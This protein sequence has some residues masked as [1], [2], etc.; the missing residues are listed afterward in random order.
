MTEAAMTVLPAPGAVTLTEVR[1]LVLPSAE[2]MRQQIEV[3][4]DIVAAQE[5]RRQLEA[6]RKYFQDRE[7]RDLLAA[8]SRRTEILIGKL[9]GPAEQ[10]YPGKNGSPTGEPFEVS[11]NDRHKFRLLAAHAEEVEKL[12]TEGTVSRNAILERIQRRETAREPGCTADLQRLVGTGKTFGAIY[13]DPPWQYGN[14]ATRASTDNHYVTM[15]VDS[16]AELPVGKL[17][18]PQS[19]LWLW[20]TNGFLFECPRLFAAWGFEFKSSYVWVK[21]Q[22]GIG[23]Y[24]RNAHEFLLLAVR[25]GL[26]ADARDVRS[27]GQFDRGEH[28][29]KPEAIR[30][31]VV[32]RISPG[33]RLELF[34]RCAVEGWTVWGNEVSRD[35]F[36]ADMESV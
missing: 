31:T 19:H 18:A 29:A 15:T 28:S 30:S 12:L 25:G 27:W 14:Q 6:F 35:L 4:G 36:T 26:T 11:K 3:R 32:E 9:M 5:L 24:L 10:T 22:F 13:A 16:L 2:K 17:A 1:T 34:G 21:P 20:T 23:N 33:P 7:G 8:E